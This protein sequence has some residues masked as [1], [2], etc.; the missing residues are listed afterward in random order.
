M[1]LSFD[2]V[3]A[4]NVFKNKEL[5]NKEQPHT[6]GLLAGGKLCISFD[7]EGAWGTFPTSN[8]PI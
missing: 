6:Y 3:T 7:H 5:L 2:C 4:A 1:S 8:N